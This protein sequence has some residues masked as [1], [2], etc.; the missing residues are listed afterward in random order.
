ME[1]PTIMEINTPE[2]PDLNCRLRNTLNPDCLAVIFEYLPVRD[3]IHLSQMNDHYKQII[4]DFI[5]HKKESILFGNTRYTD[6]VDTKSG[7][8]LITNYGDRM[9]RLRF[10]GDIYEFYAFYNLIV[11][12]FPKEQITDLEVT[13]DYSNEEVDSYYG[14]K[15]YQPILPRA[16]GHFMNLEKLQIKCLDHHEYKLDAINKMLSL[17]LVDAPNLKSLKLLQ[18]YV[19]NNRLSSLLIN[20]TMANLTELHLEDVN[21]DLEFLIEFIQKTP[22]LERFIVNNGLLNEHIEILGNILA[23]YCG[24]K[25]HTF[26]DITTDT[27]IGETIEDNIMHA[28]RYKFL[29]KFQNLQN[30]TI[31]SN[32]ACAS[33]MYYPIIELAK[34]NTVEKLGIYQN[35]FMNE[36]L[37]PEHQMNIVSRKLNKLIEVSMMVDGRQSMFVQDDQFVEQLTLRHNVKCKRIVN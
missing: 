22:N 28:N 12:Q 25:L 3:L 16:L 17:V 33:D 20:G 10:H 23:T 13:I 1:K 36:T 7:E 21:I 19:N 9:K 18:L 15:N 8:Y 14:N 2:D 30:V 34:R 26:C 5:I 32:C 24:D 27:W 37:F 31:T 6:V 4:H 35:F 11:L 29:S